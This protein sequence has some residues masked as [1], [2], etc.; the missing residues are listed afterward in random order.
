MAG[1]V[2]RLGPCRETYSI[3]I[4]FPFDGSQGQ[5]LNQFEWA[6]PTP[7]PL[8]EL[9]NHRP[10]AVIPWESALTVDRSTI[11]PGAQKN[12]SYCAY[13]P[14]RPQVRKK[15]LNESCGATHTPKCSHG[16]ELFLLRSVPLFHSIYECI[17]RRV[18]HFCS[19]SQCQIRSSKTVS[20]NWGSC[21]HTAMLPTFLGSPST[22]PMTAPWTKSS[23]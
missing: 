17:S 18:G 20:T 12:L 3:A 4:N 22:C 9:V 5:G 16:C 2:S 1:A 7:I 15:C 11:A 6:L 8:T 10:W 13:Q 21:H 14:F 23:W 19:L